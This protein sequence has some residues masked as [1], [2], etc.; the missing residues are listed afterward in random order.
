MAD[1]VSAGVEELAELRANHLTAPVE[2]SW[3]TR[4]EFSEDLRQTNLLA[5]AYSSPDFPNL[6]QIPSA[7]LQSYVRQFICFKSLTDPRTWD[8]NQFSRPSLEQAEGLA[9]DI[10]EV[11]QF[12]DLPIDVLLGIG[13]M[14]N[15]F[16]NAPGDLNNAIWKRD[17]GRDDIVLQHR[18]RKAWVLNSSM[19]IWQIT[20]QSLR[21]AH[22]LFLCDTRDY[23]KLPVRLRPTD[24]LDM[25]FLSS[26]LLTTYAA[27]LLRDLVDYF[28][29]DVFL[30]TGAYNGTK[31]HPIYNM[32]PAWRT[33]PA[34]PEESWG[35]VAFTLP[36]HYLPS[37]RFVHLSCPEG[38]QSGQN[39]EDNN[40]SPER[41]ASQ[42]QAR[43]YRSSGR[44]ARPHLLRQ[45]GR[46]P[47]IR[48]R[49]PEE[50]CRRA[51]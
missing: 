37:D 49:G 22:E 32:L 14:E 42:L 10:I 33:L 15:N 26:H 34:T 35:T 39:P 30:A 48:G 18:G 50:P 24:Q 43:S 31:L 41:K 9:E 2:Y 29:G 19:G 38:R 13:A 5:Q 4:P 44:S 28:N 46:M 8:E 36:T 20:R 3:I 21:H 16:L 7:E 23:S 6:E 11:A 12:Y 27:L 51:S 1:D 45:V 17:I 25:N 40:I 47:S